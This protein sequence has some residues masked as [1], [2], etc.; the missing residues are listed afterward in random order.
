[1]APV[2]RRSFLAGLIATAPI[3]ASV[4]A[5]SSDGEHVIN[6]WRV[7]W[8][9]WRE[10]ANQLV[11]VG[12]WV[13]LPPSSFQPPDGDA[14]GIYCSTTGAHGRYVDGY[15]LDCSR[16]DSSWP[17]SSVRHSDSEFNVAKA[18]ALDT[19]E[20]WIRKRDTF[21]YNTGGGA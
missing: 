6:G 20:I 18:R 2:S 3:A 21:I 9:G 14:R 12:F 13:G 16:W 19:V 15:T 1:M 4:G 8:S 11:R 5:A 17:V 10:P 7:R